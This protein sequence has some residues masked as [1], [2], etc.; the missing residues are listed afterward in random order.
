MFYLSYLLRHRKWIITITV[1]SAI[2]AVGF[3]VLTLALPPEKSPLPNYY[4]A[5]AV[6][7][8]GQ[9]NGGDM[10]SMLT[11]LGIQ[12]PIGRDEMNYGELGVRVLHSRPF[13][14]QIIKKHNIIQRYGIVEKVKT[15]S[16]DIVNGSS[17]IQYDSRTGTLRIGYEAID[18]VFARDVVESMVSGLQAWFKNWDGN[19]TQQQLLAIEEKIEEVSREIRRHEEEIQNFQTEYG[20]FSVEQLAQAQTGMITDLQAQLIQT[21]VAIKNYSGF[22]NIE[23]PELIRLQAQRES[24]KD[25]IEQIESGETVGGRQMPSRAELPAL[26]IKYSHLRMSHEI[27]MRIYQNLQEQYEVQ[28]LMSTGSSVFSILEPAEVPEEKSRPQRSRLCMIITA[29]GFFGSIALALFF[30]LIRSIRNDPY[31]KNI[32]MGKN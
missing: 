3:S 4:R 25:L 29:A 16:R 18:P 15:T 14:D 21:E 20:V 32:L 7:I 17:Q 2:I 8:V 19:S 1:L 6:L 11:A 28:K 30:D 5:Y 27:Q 9:G 26:A 12:S 22:S 23:D 24:L 13:L 10:M 31:K